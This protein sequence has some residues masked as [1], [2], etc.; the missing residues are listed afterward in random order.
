M[1]FMVGV[2]APIY[3]SISADIFQGRNFGAI[4]GVMMMGSAPRAALGA[5]LGEYI[6]DETGSYDF[7][8]ILVMITAALSIVCVWLAAPRKVRMAFGVAKKRSG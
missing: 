1:G 8:F 2:L 3:P 7:A 5:W 6:N 4:Q